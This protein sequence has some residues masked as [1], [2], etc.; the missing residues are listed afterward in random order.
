MPTLCTFSHSQ[1]PALLAEECLRSTVP[2]HHQL[3]RLLRGF[4]P[5]QLDP[6]PHC[7]LHAD[8]QNLRQQSTAHPAETHPRTSTISCAPQRTAGLG[9]VR[10]DAS[11]TR[12]SCIPR[13]TTVQALSRPPRRGF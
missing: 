6:Q 12:G 8:S 11:A 5:C 1:V 13:K 9:G 2:H 3:R 7:L 4:L 10:P